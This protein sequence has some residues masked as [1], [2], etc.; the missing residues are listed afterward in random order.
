MSINDRIIKI[1]K[2]ANVPA[3]TIKLLVY[4]VFGKNIT[5]NVENNLNLLEKQY[6]LQ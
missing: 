1:A 4:S 3:S 6:G 2:K 5:P